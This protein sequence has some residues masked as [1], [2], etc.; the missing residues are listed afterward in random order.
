MMIIRTN[1]G[2]QYQA[3]SKDNGESW[4]PSEITSI[5]SPVSPATIARIPSTGDLL[6]VWN[7][8]GLT[9]PLKGLRTPLSIAVS[10]D[11]GKTWQHQK[12]LENDPEGWYCYTAI[13][14]VGKKEVLLSYC[15]GN[16]PEGTGLSITNIRRLSLDWIY[17]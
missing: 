3:F 14:F 8:N 16:R 7:N 13:H 2:F 17:K 11:E 10:K 12:T 9:G 4:G 15:A 6:M 1:A 5:Q